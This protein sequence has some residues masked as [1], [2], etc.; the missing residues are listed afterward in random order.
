M[1]FSL[2]DQRVK[3]PGHQNAP[4]RGGQSQFVSMSIRK[5]TGCTNRTWESL[6]WFEIFASMYMV[7]ARGDVVGST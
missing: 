3:H 5:F 7:G 2:A 4:P 6:I 1:C